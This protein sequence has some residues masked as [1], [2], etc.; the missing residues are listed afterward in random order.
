MVR[1]RCLIG[2]LL[3]TRIWL[4][5]VVIVTDRVYFRWTA[6]GG[7]SVLLIAFFAS[8]ICL[9]NFRELASC[10]RRARQMITVV[11]RCV[12]HIV[13]S[14]VRQ[15]PPFYIMASLVTSPHHITNE[16]VTYPASVWHPKAE[17]FSAS[18]GLRPL[19]L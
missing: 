5:Q 1:I 17:R 4:L 19:T 6:I 11:R 8:P 2:K 9:F 12:A 13:L 14:T 16:A 10:G 3:C 18:K 7:A 15:L